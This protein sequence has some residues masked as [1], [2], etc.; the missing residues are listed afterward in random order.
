[1]ACVVVCQLQPPVSC[2]STNTAATQ[3]TV[4]LHRAV[5][6]IT[7]L[8]VLMHTHAWVCTQPC[9]VF[10]VQVSANIARGE[11]A[12]YSERRVLCTWAEHLWVEALFSCDMKFKY[13]LTTDTMPAWTGQISM[14]EIWNC[15]ESSHD[16][17]K[18]G[19]LQYPTMRHV[20]MHQYQ[21]SIHI[22]QC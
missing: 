6:H 14:V 12:G 5:L 9:W 11:S 19:A 21:L 4:L 10:V 13:G 2:L 22:T 17:N 3:V 20:T 15:E 16:Y 7:T 1:M 8:L 18:F